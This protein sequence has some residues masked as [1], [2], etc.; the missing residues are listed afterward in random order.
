MALL[1]STHRAAL[2]RE[3]RI[4]RRNFSELLLV[5]VRSGTN[6][7]IP[8]SGTA[9]PIPSPATA[10][11][12]TI[13]RF[14]LPQGGAIWRTRLATAPRTIRHASTAKPKPASKPLVL[15]K[16][17]KFNPPSHGSKPR[18][19]G[20]RYPGPALSHEQAAAQKTKQYPNMMPP[21]G[22]FMHWFLHNRSIHIYITL[23]TLFSMAGFTWLT[24]FKHTSKFADLLP[25][26]S[27]L[28]F[29]PLRWARQVADVLR[30]H[31]A[32]VSAETAERRQ[33]K[34]D[35]VAKRAE[36][37]KAHGLE[38]EGFGG[39]TA[40][41]DAESLGPAIPYD[42]RVPHVATE[43]AVEGAVEGQE[44]VPRQKKQVKK[45]LGIW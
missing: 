31:A 28:F 40:K 19:A 42:G 36:F 43:G 13:P 39:W 38:T 1:A 2:R 26:A 24:N 18:T 12:T 33:A 14:L 35:D 5:A 25:S 22:S 3:S 29:H 32:A 41:T 17:T 4:S 34:V 23:G 6:L 20:P 37:R 30:M 15:E 16:P 10:M 45:W 21:A 8:S 7:T 11:S 44:Q 9:I 27:D